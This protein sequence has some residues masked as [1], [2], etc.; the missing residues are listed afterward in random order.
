[1][2][3]RED[4]QPPAVLILNV[5][6]AKLRVKR[7]AL[8]H[9]DDSKLAWMFS[10][11]WDH[12]LPRDHS[13]R[14]FL[15]LDIKWF[16]PI[17]QYLSELSRGAAADAV[18]LP[19]TLLSDDD[20][21][22]LRACVELFGLCDVMPTHALDPHAHVLASVA[23][24]G[25]ESG[26]NLGWAGP[27]QLLYQLST[28][29]AA[30]QEFHRLCDGQAN[31]VC[32]A[33]DDKGNVFGGFTSVGWRT[34]GSWQPDH[35]AFLFCKGS[36]VTATQRYYQNG[37]HPQYAV[38]QGHD[39]PTFG[40][41][42]DLCFNFSVPDKMTYGSSTHT[43]HPMP[44]NGTSNG[45]VTDLFIW[46]VRQIGDSAQPLPPHSSADAVPVHPDGG[47]GCSSD[48]TP[49]AVLCAD[50]PGLTGPA[51]ALNV[52]SLWLK[53]QLDAY[54][55]EMQAVARRAEMFASER[56][57][58]QQL[59]AA[60]PQEDMDTRKKAWLEQVQA[61]DTHPPAP[62]SRLRGVHNGIV[63]I[64]CSGTGQ[65]CTMRDTFTQFGDTPLANKYASD[66]WGGNVEVELDEEGCVFEDH[67]QEC[68]D[69]L[70]NVMRLRAIVRRPGF[71][72]TIG[73]S[74]PAPMPAHLAPTMANMLEYLMIDS[75][76]FF[77]SLDSPICKET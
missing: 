45:A 9:V 15:D 36:G 66:V 6:G 28:H 40:A 35:A 54:D 14:I 53:E 29:G 38:Y 3:R 49:P 71:S 25:Q 70:V 10:G 32:L 76:L 67:N 30:P 37:T 4:Y 26:L 47:L 8:T 33:V 52:F 77:S 43:Y 11:R 22:G 21:L 27:W 42:H 75:K 58:M 55:G 64:A 44:V 62:P 19:I 51:T 16:S 39:S 34:G 23:C 63:Y 57:F 41:G 61:G 18:H 31:T 60:L 17:T 59:N 72:G 7:S 5:G 74:K 46:Q 12:V 68:F 13:G 48:T 24:F 73:S 56:A 2:P 69:K 65:L 50:E 1:M 20:R